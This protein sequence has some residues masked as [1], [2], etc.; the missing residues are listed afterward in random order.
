MRNL[1]LVVALAVFSFSCSPPTPES[2]SA[3]NCASGCCD[4]SGVCRS[5]SSSAECGKGG[6]M[7]ASCSFAQAC[8]ANACTTTGT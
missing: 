8:V 4:S 3:S 6:A 2:C 7:C 5:G 1:L